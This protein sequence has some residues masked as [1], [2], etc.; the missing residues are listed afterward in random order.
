MGEEGGFVGG[1]VGGFADCCVG[2][3]VCCLTGCCTEGRVDCSIVGEFVG[4][5]VVAFC[6]PIIE[7]GENV[8]SVTGPRTKIVVSEVALSVGDNVL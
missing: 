5:C 1:G 6:D 3:S 8:N 4:D 2:G 7:V